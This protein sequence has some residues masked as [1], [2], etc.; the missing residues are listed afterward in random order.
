METLVFAYGHCMKNRSGHGVLRGSRL[1]GRGKA[2][3]L[4]LLLLTP[5]LAVAVPEPGSEI[6]GEVYAVNQTTLAFL[7]RWQG[8][9]RLFRR[10]LFPIAMEQG[11]TVLAWVYLWMHRRENPRRC[12]GGRQC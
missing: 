1:L 2:K 10:T 4:G 7:D 11:E 9:G 8:E 6:C 12:R 3:D 5:R